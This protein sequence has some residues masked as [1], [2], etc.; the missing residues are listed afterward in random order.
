MHPWITGNGKDLYF[1]RK[2]GEGWRVYVASRQ[3]T[4]G[5]GGFGEPKLVELPADFHHATL[6]PDGTTMYLQGPLEG[7]RWGLFRSAK[8]S[9]AW[10]KP[11]PVD[12]LNNLEAPTADRSQCLSRD[13]SMLYFSSD[14]I[15]GKGGLD[16][17]M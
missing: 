17:W 11:E 8:V 3:A 1:S 4:T 15:G 14:R 6:S 7:K 13:G 10:S 12:D 16:I 5:A 9:G 2:T